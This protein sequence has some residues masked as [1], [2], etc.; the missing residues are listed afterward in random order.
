MTVRARKERKVERRYK[1]VFFA[2]LIIVGLG[3]KAGHSVVLLLLLSLLKV[4][5]EPSAA[6]KNPC[7]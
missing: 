3:N 2:V 1:L 6:P 7:I 4:D 5:V